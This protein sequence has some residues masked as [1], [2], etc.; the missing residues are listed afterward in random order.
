MRE[1]SYASASPLFEVKRYDG[2]FFDDLGLRVLPAPQG[3]TAAER[4]AARWSGRRGQSHRA[5]G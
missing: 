4:F 5:A 1:I 2:E 3:G